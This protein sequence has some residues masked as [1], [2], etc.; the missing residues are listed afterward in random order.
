MQ[1][2]NRRHGLNSRKNIQIVQSIGISSIAMADIK[3]QTAL[4]NIEMVAAAR[5]AVFA[6]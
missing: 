1:I 5:L 4:I 6:E 2:K 3:T